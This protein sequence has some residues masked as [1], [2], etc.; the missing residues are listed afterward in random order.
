MVH[1]AHPHLEPVS[2]HAPARE[3][4]LARWSSSTI[5]RSFNPRP[6]AGSDS[7]SSRPG[8]RSGSCF[9]PRPRAGSDWCGGRMSA[10]P[11]QCFNP[12]PRAGSDST[13][14]ATTLAC[15]YGFNPRPR[16]GSDRIT[17]R[18]D[19]CQRQFQSTPPRG[20][21][22]AVRGAG[23][24]VTLVFQSTPARGK[25]HRRPL[26]SRPC[27]V[28][29]HAPAREAT[30]RLPP[31]AVSGQVSIHAPA[32]E[33]TSMACAAEYRRGKKFQSTPPRGKRRA[34]E[35]ASSTPER[36]FQS[37]PPRG[38]ATWIP[39][40]VDEIGTVSIHAPAREATRHVPVHAF[41]GRQVSIHAPAREATPLATRP[42][43]A[44]CFN[45]RPRAG[46]D[47]RGDV[48]GRELVAVSIHAP[49]REATLLSLLD[50]PRDLVSIHAPAPGSDSA[51]K[52]FTSGT[53]P[54]Q[55]TPPR[56]KRHALRA[57]PGAR[58]GVR[59]N[60]R[61]RAGS[62]AT[63]EAADPLQGVSIHAPA[64]EA[65]HAVRGGTTASVLFQ[66]T[67]PGGKRRSAR[68]TAAG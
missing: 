3:A 68:G 48:A 26:P 47:R 56:G 14:P 44:F 54:F 28:S 45:P 1:D 4:T 60:P 15:G 37:T 55:S 34:I 24:D 41:T 22:P 65:T 30:S 59:F 2:I 11:S 52:C 57:L 36:L 9:N 32:R 58:R 67:P 20:K 46:S 53:C 51:M 38:E 7:G 19:P 21:R 40:G 31:L 64:R 6:R 33:A 63:Y 13:K 43:R 39:S 10:V 66:S 62:D 61:P 17:K 29:I 42:D 16:A 18:Q 25:R 27:A 8:A 50:R 35:K 23:A 49:A 5:V 12:R